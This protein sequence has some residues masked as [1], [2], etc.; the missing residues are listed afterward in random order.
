[1]PTPTGHRPQLDG[2]RALAIAGVLLSHFHG[3]FLAETLAGGGVRLFFVLSGFL[4]TGMLLAARARR[5]AGEP[6]P[7]RNFYIRRVLRLW[8]AY[9]LLLGIAVAFNI[10]DIRPVALWHALLSSNILFALRGDFVPWPT[11]PWWSLSVE[12][13]FYAAWPAVV[14][15]APRRALPAITLALAVAGYAYRQAAPFGPF[16]THY[17]PFASFDALGAGALLAMVEPTPRVLRVLRLALPVL[18]AVIGAALLWGGSWTFAIAQGLD[19]LA[20]AAVVGLAAGPGFKGVIGRLLESAPMRFIGRI[21][22]GIYLYH[23]FVLAAIFAFVSPRVPMLG[24]PGWATL[25]VAA[26]LSVLVAAASWY[27]LEAPINRTKRR[28]PYP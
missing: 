1:M 6:A 20:F 11:G 19:A 25:A 13:Q 8:P 27:L 3:G 26:P 14:L 15:F 18:L 16:A 28:F 2:L 21:S 23:M 22:Y 9:F 4:I 24:Q 12:E 10:E 17:L 7:L 5:E